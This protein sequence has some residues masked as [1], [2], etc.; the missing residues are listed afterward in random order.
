MYISCLSILCLDYLVF[1][2]YI[3]PLCFSIYIHDLDGGIFYLIELIIITF[4]LR[5][6]IGSFKNIG[7]IYLETPDY[8]QKSISGVYT[9]LGFGYH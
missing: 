2:F 8:I 1:S 7:K 4:S 9:S 6:S 3:F 5:Y